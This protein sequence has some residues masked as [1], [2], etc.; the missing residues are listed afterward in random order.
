LKDI[1]IFATSVYSVP[2]ALRDLPG[3]TF[4][5]RNADLELRPEG[6]LY[7]CEAA[8]LWERSLLFGDTCG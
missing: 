7:F 1:L 3:V 5:L 4:H 2:E 8:Q 6:T